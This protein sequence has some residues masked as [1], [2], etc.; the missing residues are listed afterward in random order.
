MY[1]YCSTNW[2]RVAQSRTGHPGITINPWHLRAPAVT[3]VYGITF[4]TLSSKKPWDPCIFMSVTEPNLAVR[5]IYPGHSSVISTS[6]ILSR[7]LITPG[8]TALPCLK[9][10]KKNPRNLRVTP[11][12]TQVLLLPFLQSWQKKLLTWIFAHFGKPH[13]H[14][15]S[16]KEIKTCI[17][18][19]EAWS[20]SWILSCWKTSRHP[21]E[22]C[23]QLAVSSFE[24]P[25]QCLWDSFQSASLVS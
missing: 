18:W 12:I 21:Q 14:I 4:I 19:L 13:H 8:T 23:F 24:L 20:A 10:K 5:G 1:Q 15:N 17:H 7:S 9:K 2:R 6:L 16:E 11:R 25:E 22:P 3:P